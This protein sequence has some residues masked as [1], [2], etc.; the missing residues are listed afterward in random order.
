MEK[1]PI[2]MKVTKAIEVIKVIKPNIPSGERFTHLHL[3]G[4]L[5]LNRIPPFQIEVEVHKLW[6]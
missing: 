4:R 3:P 2:F 5:G 6:C 1:S